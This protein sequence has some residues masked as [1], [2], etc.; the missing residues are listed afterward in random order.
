MKYKIYQLIDP[1]KIRYGFMEINFIE[2]KGIKISPEDYKIVYEGEIQGHND[3]NIMLENLFAT[4][5]SGNLPGDYYGHSLSMSDVVELEGLG[6]Y[7]VDRV[8]FEKLLPDWSLDRA[9]VVVE[10]QEGSI[11]FDYQYYRNL[12]E[13]R[14]YVI[15]SY[16][17]CRKEEFFKT[18]DQKKETSE[19]DA[20]WFCY[21]DYY[22]FYHWIGIV[23]VPRTLWSVVE[24]NAH[25]GLDFAP[26]QKFYSAS[27]AGEEIEKKFTKE[28]VNQEIDW[29][30]DDYIH[31]NSR[32]YM[33]NID[34][35]PCLT[36]G[37][38]ID[39]DF[40]VRTR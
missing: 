28:M 18:V 16:K 2:E 15:A 4:L 21:R 8:G 36:G 5:N 3:P 32:R 39:P 30:G 34:A 1:R 31:Q 6:L 40:S 9:Y 25:P 27:I 7:Y 19:D 37:L 26:I 38:L 29:S 14:D 11:Y 23:T 24:F 22:D 35:E 12:L 13:A 33:I 20:R 10:I 17:D